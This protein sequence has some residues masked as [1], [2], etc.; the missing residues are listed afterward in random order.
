MATLVP[1]PIPSDLRFKSKV[2]LVPSA[3]DKIRHLRGV[4]FAGMRT[5][6]Y[7]SP[8]TSRPPFPP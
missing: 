2:Q 3:L 5:Q 8:E 1:H 4:S 6:C 7:V